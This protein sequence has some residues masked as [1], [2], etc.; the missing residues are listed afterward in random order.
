[1]EKSAVK[2]SPG[3]LKLH[4]SKALLMQLSTYSSVLMLT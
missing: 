4:N 3:T 2:Y 1:M